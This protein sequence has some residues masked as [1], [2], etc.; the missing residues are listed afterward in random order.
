M[1]K[2]PDIFCI[3]LLAGICGLNNSCIERFEPEVQGFK[4]ILVVDGLITDREEAYTILLS[5]SR[6]LNTQDTVYESLA[7]VKVTDDDN[8]SFH[9]RESKPGV[10]QSNP[11]EFVGQVGENYFLDIITSEGEHYQ[12]SPVLLKQTPP[13]DS[14]YFERQLR[15]DDEGVTYQGIAVLLDTHD[16]QNSTNYYR[17]EWQEDWEV[18]V[19]YPNQYEWIPLN[20]QSILRGYFELHGLDLRICYDSGAGTNIQVETS[21]HLAEDRIS[22][23]ELTYVTDQ[24]HKQSSLYSILVRQYALDSLEFTYWSELKKLSESLGTLFDPQPYELN[25]NVF[26]VEDPDEP[27]V[28]FFGASTVSEKRVFISKNELAAMGPFYFNGSCASEY[29]RVSIDSIGYFIANQYLIAA[30][31]YR[32]DHVFMAPASCSDCRFSGTADKPD[33][34]PR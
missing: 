14:I 17:W 10:Y 32:A 12:S 16:P 2:P 11:L 34:W 31:P 21:A 15:T 20:T 7:E 4:S 19:P 24:G 27:V 26:N 13:I 18:A 33:F 8:N 5:R 28:G 9:F 22:N 6:A 25:G 29:V 3:L 23:Y 30:V 1:R